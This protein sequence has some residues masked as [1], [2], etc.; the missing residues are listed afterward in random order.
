MAKLTFDLPKPMEASNDCL[1]HAAMN[2][3]KAQGMGIRPAAMVARLV[4]DEQ[5]G[6]FVLYRI[7]ADGGFVGD[8]W[9]GSLDD[10][11]WQV[12][13]EFGIDYRKRDADA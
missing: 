4:V 6:N 3:G 2:L 13:K 9:H 10:A 5:Y 11:L 12:K 1:P 8:S 7:D